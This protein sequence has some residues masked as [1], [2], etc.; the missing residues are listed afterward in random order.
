MITKEASVIY[1]MLSSS[2]FLKKKIS[3]NHKEII[4]YRSLRTVLWP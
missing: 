2:D 3:Q 1:I 4:E